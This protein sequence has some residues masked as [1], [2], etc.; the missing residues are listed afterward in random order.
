MKPTIYLPTAELRAT[1]LRRTA[2]G[3]A[4]RFNAGHSASD[5]PWTSVEGRQV[6][7]NDRTNQT[8]GSRGQTRAT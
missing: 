5:R 6:G 7:S 1:G 4:V 8:A 3:S 2:A